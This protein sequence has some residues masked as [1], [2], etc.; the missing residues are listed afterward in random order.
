[1]GLLVFIGFVSLVRSFFR[2][3]EP[4]GYLAWKRLALISLAVVLF[5]LIVRGA[6]LVV[7]IYVIATVGAY[8]SRKFKWLPTVLLATG[9]VVFCVLAFIQGLGIPLPVFGYWFTD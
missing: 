4:V 7:A 2:D 3:G 9:L 6:G 5:G 8:A 1:S